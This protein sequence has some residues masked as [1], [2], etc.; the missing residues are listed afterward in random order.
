MP[1]RSVRWRRGSWMAASSVALFANTG[2]AQDQSAGE[3]EE[4]VVTGVRAAQQAAIDIKRD[5]LQIVDAISAEDIGKLPDVTISDSLQ[6]IPG[7][8][9]RRDAGEGS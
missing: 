9:V 7:I 5:S 3:L 6:R 8:Q 4:V 1:T 2:L